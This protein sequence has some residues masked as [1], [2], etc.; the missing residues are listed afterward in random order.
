M[1]TLTTAAGDY[2]TAVL[3][4]AN[5]SEHTAI[6]GRDRDRSFSSSIARRELDRSATPKPAFMCSMSDGNVICR[7]G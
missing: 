7:L 5:A 4:T 3:Q 6:R 1:L 2:L